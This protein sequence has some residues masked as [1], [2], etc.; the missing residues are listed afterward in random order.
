ML[1]PKLVEEKPALLKNSL[2]E[3][4]FKEMLKDA[5]SFLKLRKDWRDLKTKVDKLR[6]QR[7][8]VSKAINEAIKAG[9]KQEAAKKK[10]EARKVSGGVKKADDR[11]SE[12]EKRLNILSLEFPNLAIDLPKKD[13]VL[14]EVGKIKRE[15][16]MKSYE[17]IA[18]SLNLMDFNSS[19]QMSGTGFYTLIGEGAKLERALTNFFLDRGKKQGYNEISPP[20]LVTER[21][22]VNSGH[23]PKFK[24]GM[25]STQDG[26]YLIPT[27]EVPLLNLYAGKTLREEQLPIYLAAFS[28][29]FRVEKG[30]TRGYMRVKQFTKV[31]LLKFVRQEDSFEELDKMLKD[32]TETLK[33][34][35]IPFR[36]KLLSAEE[37]GFAAAKTYDLD[38]YAPGSNEWLEVSSV[39]NCTDF[40]ARRARIKY[41]T[42]KG[43]RK[44][45]HTLN[46]SGLAIPRTFIAI[47]E[48]LQQKDGSIKIPKALKSYFGKD[49]I[50]GG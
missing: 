23:L 7:N 39:S 48:N 5:D 10:K 30:A 11:I 45:V 20:L 26:L 1:D 14:K 28:P 24:E 18:S 36:T 19:V 34:L 25:F 50:P 16:W 38:V 12:I 32:V 49:K 9:K 4:G 41:V 35:E 46:G 27:S 2:K 3:R 47:L 29:C 37:T 40:Q 22:M 15:K 6:H 13:K 44:F 31:E 33:L 43:E 8:V 21:A 17:E 42:K